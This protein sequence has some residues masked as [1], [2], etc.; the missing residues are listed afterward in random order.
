MEPM[1]FWG[2]SNCQG[3]EGKA[4]P[5]YQ[6]DRF[7]KNRFK[8]MVAGESN[9]ALTGKVEEWN[10]QPLTNHLSSG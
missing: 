10:K 9:K 8:D 1:V 7:I 3:S 5:F 4:F 6:D 2:R